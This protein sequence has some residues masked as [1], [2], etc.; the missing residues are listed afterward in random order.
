[1]DIFLAVAQLSAPV[2]FQLSLPLKSLFYRLAHDH[3]K[4]ATNGNAQPDAEKTSDG[5]QEKAGD[6]K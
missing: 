4:G 6:C 2:Q 5:Q 3:F 1:L